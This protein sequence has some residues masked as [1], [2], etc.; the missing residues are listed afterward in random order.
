MRRLHVPGFILSMIAEFRKR[1]IAK[2]RHRYL[3]RLSRRELADICYGQYDQGQQH[4]VVRPYC[5]T[6][7]E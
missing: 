6:T 7:R 1:Q 2:E 3:A 4:E 5:V